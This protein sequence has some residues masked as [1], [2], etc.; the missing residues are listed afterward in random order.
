MEAVETLLHVP[1]WLFSPS[2]DGKASHL[3]CSLET[4]SDL[5]LLCTKAAFP[6][7]GEGGHRDGAGQVLGWHGYSLGAL[8]CLAFALVVQDTLDQ[9]VVLIQH[10]GE[11]QAGCMQGHTAGGL[12]LGCQDPSGVC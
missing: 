9:M 2:P 3:T 10:L 12:H 4:I 8:S 1:P 7:H 5:P 6:A 11:R